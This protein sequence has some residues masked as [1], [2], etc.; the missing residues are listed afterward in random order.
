[1]TLLA[2]D[3][4]TMI[5]AAGED[6]RLAV[7]RSPA[8]RE[9]FH[10]VCQKDQV[11]R[12]DVFD[13]HDIHE[14]ARDV[15]YA[16]LERAISPPETPYG[17][18]LLLLGEA[19]SG[20]THLMRAFRH[21]VHGNRLGYCGYLQMTTA[22]ENYGRYVLANLIDSLDDPYFEGEIDRSGLMT[23]SN[24]LV[25]NSGL[26][27]PEDIERLRTGPMPA[28]DLARLT[29]RMADLFVSDKRFQH[30]DPDVLRAVCYLQRDEAR[31]KSRVLKFL[32]CE[33]LGDFDRTYIPG[34]EP[35]LHDHHPQ[36]M[37]EHLGRLMWAVEHRSLVLLVDQMEDM[38]NFDFDPRRAEVRFR[39]AVQTI[40]AMAGAIPSSVFVVSCLEDFYQHLRDQ[41]TGSARDRIEQDPE[42]VRLTA[43][44]TA[45]EVEKIVEYRLGALYS[46]A[47]VESGEP[48][49]PFP[50]DFLGQLAGLRTRDV[51]D[52]CRKFRIAGDA[53]YEIDRHESAVVV[54]PPPAP[55]FDL[56]QAWNDFRTSYKANVPES[57]ELQAE[58]LAAAI[59]ACHLDMP[60]GPRFTVEL[61][62]RQ[63]IVGMT[64]DVTGGMPGGGDSTSTKL[65]V[66]MCN[67][68]ATGGHLARQVGE[69][70]KAAGD[71][72]PVIVRSG[73][74]PGDPRS[75]IAGILSEFQKAGGRRATVEDSH[76]RMLLALE[77][78]HLEH[79]GHPQYAGW[80]QSD[81]PLARLKPLI[82]IL[83]LDNRPGHQP[84]GPARE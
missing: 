61:D 71:R 75:R 43:T 45:D 15:F 79:S 16:T 23:L 73:E 51:L 32:R 68:T 84:E 66:A 48:H 40:C 65:L 49:F 5:E 78:F 14:P 18:L 77:Q 29:V 9:A 20:K 76:W 41:L 67:K 27:S 81:R 62:E 30:L 4:R 35:R 10:S 69:V 74:F 64:V 33:P 56:Q 82:D 53:N 24:A 39:R 46:A 22:T 60:D 25:Q 13:V 17:H 2:M 44:R 55:A 42:P 47:G 26:I 34:L 11:W 63:L 8:A 7:F 1:M 52:R 83:Q 80:R 72:I 37:V 50:P 59:A 57:D 36:S 28:M 12:R 58:V 6:P 54:T 31:L 3:P 19:G 21:Y 38:A 70:Q